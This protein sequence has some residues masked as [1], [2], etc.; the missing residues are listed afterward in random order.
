MLKA[1]GIC[2]RVKIVKDVKYRGLL[3]NVSK[4]GARMSGPIPN[5]ITN[6]VWQP[7]T[8]FLSTFRDS[9]IWSIPGVNMLLARGLITKKG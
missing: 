7:I 5:M 9:A 2:R 1:V 6:P 8:L 4:R 3:P